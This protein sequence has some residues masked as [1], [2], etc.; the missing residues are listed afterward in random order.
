MRVGWHDEKAVAVGRARRARVIVAASKMPVG[1]M[2]EPRYVAEGAVGMGM[3][4]RERC[5]RETGG[6]SESTRKDLWGAHSIFFGGAH[7][8]QTERKA[9]RARADPV[10]SST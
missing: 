3:P 7:V 4:L 1:E 10:K 8:E 2:V 9:N 5:G 6:A